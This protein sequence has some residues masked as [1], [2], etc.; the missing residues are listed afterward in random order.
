[1]RGEVLAA[2][3]LTAAGI[4]TSEPGC[5]ET[6]P[7]CEDVNQYRLEHDRAPLDQRMT[8]QESASAWAHELAESGNLRHSPA[9]LR[10]EYGGEIVGYGPDWATVMAAWDKSDPHRAVML[11][12]DLTRVGIG[13]AWG[14]GRVWA[15][16]VFR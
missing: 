11:D 14:D 12:G 2:V 3:L 4:T 9:A 1:V 10:G 13:K 8:L 5:W 16:V 7:R 15:V 6:A